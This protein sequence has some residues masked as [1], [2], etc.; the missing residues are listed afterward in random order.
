MARRLMHF[1]DHSF[2][3]HFFLDHFLGLGWGGFL[4]DWMKM[5]IQ[6]RKVD[7]RKNHVFFLNLE[8]SFFRHIDI[9][10]IHRYTRTFIG[11]IT[12]SNQLNH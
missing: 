10:N 4:L 8:Y 7:A 1:L 9:T 5:M 3:E 2:G 11:G 12:P 6:L